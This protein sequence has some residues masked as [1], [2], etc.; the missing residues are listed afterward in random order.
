MLKPLKNTAISFSADIENVDG[1]LSQESEINFYRIVQE[2]LS[3]I[4]KHSDAANAWL[5]IKTNGNRVELSCRDDG[6]GFDVAVAKN[7]PSSGLGLNGMA[8]RAR[9][10]GA[11]LRIESGSGNGTTIFVSVPAKNQT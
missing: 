10:I 11:D 9:I 5:N 8:E 1:R 4:L 6:K 3:N 7:S 2:C